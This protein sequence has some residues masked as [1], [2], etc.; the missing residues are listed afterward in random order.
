MSKIITIAHQKGGVGKSTLALN[1][2]Y[3]FALKPPTAVIDLDQQGT[4]ARLKDL[5]P[6]DGPVILQDDTLTPK[7]ITI[8]YNE[9]K[10]I[11]IDTPPYNNDKLPALLAISDVVIIPTKAGIPDA[12]AIQNT[13]A[14][15][16]AAQ[17]KKKDLQAGIVINM[18]KPRSALTEEAKNHLVKYDIPI[19][20]EIGDR[21]AYG[22][23]LYTGGVI[24]GT[25]EL[26][27]YE[28]NNL[29]LQIL[30]MVTGVDLSKGE[31]HSPHVNV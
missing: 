13:V 2:A 23:T 19:I 15:V 29:V 7:G 10:M 31:L 20:A 12:M 22:R 5:I 25:D 30:R 27:K 9:F 21:V 24:A 11:V 16:K 18:I 28:I 26:A 3:A 8:Q 4:I 14:I 6:A 1:L 17:A